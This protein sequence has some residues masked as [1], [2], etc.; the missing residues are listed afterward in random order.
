MASADKKR[1]GE[2]LCE[3]GFLST[4]QLEEGL[5][6]Q[7]HCYKNRPLG[8][9]LMDLGYITSEQLCD[10]VLIQTKCQVSE[11]GGVHLRQ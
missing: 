5:E 10:A 6:K 8:Q 2:I 1:I 3:K 7:K 9:I 11:F 4:P